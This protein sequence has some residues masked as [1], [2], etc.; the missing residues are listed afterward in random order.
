M[1]LE[2]QH[3]S[4]RYNNQIQNLKAAHEW[5][6]PMREQ[7]GVSEYTACT[8]PEPMDKTFSMVQDGRAT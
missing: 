6:Q 4:S 5:S 2:I 3:A 1:L 8:T 7:S